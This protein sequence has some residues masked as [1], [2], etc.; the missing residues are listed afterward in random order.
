M[1]FSDHERCADAV[2]WLY[3]FLDGQL[4]EVRAT[5]IQRHLDECL[6]CLEAFDFEA[7]LRQ[8][9]AR[10]CREGVPETVRLRIIGAIQAEYRSVDGME[11]M[12]PSH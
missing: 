6:P 8:V 7:E 9:V 11:G 4:D 10:R 1:P 5:D 12:S 2:G 3:Q